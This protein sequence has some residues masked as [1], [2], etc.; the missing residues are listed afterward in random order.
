MRN[1][2]RRILLIF[3]LVACFVFVKNGA[4]ASA[5]EGNLKIVSIMSNSETPYDVPLAVD[6]VVAH[7]SSRIPVVVVYY[8]VFLNRTVQ[9]GGWRFVGADLSYRVTGYNVSVFTAHIPSPVY[10]EALPYDTKI[11][12]YVEAVD[13]GNSVLSCRQEDRWNANIQDDKL[14][15]VL[16][17]PFAPESWVLS[18]FL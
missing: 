6:I 2:I 11:V 17:D 12:F 1:L 18:F 9:S 3:L 8:A 10:N 7:N 14:V 5:E 13:G 16:T 4:V 15:F